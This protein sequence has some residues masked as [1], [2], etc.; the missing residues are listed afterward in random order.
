MAIVAIAWC[1]SKQ[2]VNPILGLNSAKRI[3]E[4]VAAIKFKLSEEEIQKLEKHY[5]PKAKPG[6]W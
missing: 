6:A 2:N 1:L 5:L 4:A 3:D